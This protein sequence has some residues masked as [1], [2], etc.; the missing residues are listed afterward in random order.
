MYPMS[1]FGMMKITKDEFFNQIKGV[2]LKKMVPN[3][4]YDPDEIK[5]KDPK[6]K[7]KIL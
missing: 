5:R 2:K 4:Y 3:K 7:V 6:K 1:Q